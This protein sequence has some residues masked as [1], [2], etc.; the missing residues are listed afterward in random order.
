M[1]SFTIKDLEELQFICKNFIKQI[2]TSS[3]SVFEIWILIIYFGQYLMYKYPEEE[4]K[5]PGRY[6]TGST[7]LR[8]L[9][10]NPLYYYIALL[11]NELV[12]FNNIGSSISYCDR[13]IEL[14]EKDTGI[15]DKTEKDV[16]DFIGREGF[17]ELRSLLTTLK[18]NKSETE[19]PALS[20]LM[21]LV[22]GE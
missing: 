19:I 11:R 22:K 9:N 10:L 13:V 7:V 18:R 1:G 5:H 14:L 15:E 12:H 16:L 2:L 20:T 21:S 8:N 3:K 17:I 4:R 6:L